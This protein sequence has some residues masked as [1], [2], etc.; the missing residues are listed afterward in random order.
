MGTIF[1]V[2]EEEKRLRGRDGGEGGECRGVLPFLI[3][4]YDQWPFKR[5]LGDLRFGQWMPVR[6]VGECEG[7]QPQTKN[8]SK[9]RSEAW[10][11]GIFDHASREC[12]PMRVSGVGTRTMV[13]IGKAPGVHSEYRRAALSDVK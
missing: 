10:K 11:A 3:A 8:N 13:G 2:K 4:F 1:I 6:P 12:G 7:S 9:E 5:S